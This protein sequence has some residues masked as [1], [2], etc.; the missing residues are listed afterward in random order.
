MGSG[1]GGVAEKGAVVG[2]VE[3]ARVVEGWLR[4]VVGCLADW[5]VVLCPVTPAVV[6][7]VL[8]PHQSYHL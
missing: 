3:R 4:R 5:V 1:R 7:V 2:L 8:T 6:K